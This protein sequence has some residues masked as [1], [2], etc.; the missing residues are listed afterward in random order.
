MKKWKKVMLGVLGVGCVCAIVPACV[1]SC[2]SIYGNYD[3][4]QSSTATT[5]EADY[6][7]AM[8]IYQAV[9]QAPILSSN[10]G[11]TIDSA[12]S[13]FSNDVNSLVAKNGWNQV[14]TN[15]LPVNMIVEGLDSA[16][17]GFSN[18]NFT[19]PYFDL[20]TFF[21]IKNFAVTQ[22]SN[23][24]FTIKANVTYTITDKNDKG[25][26]EFTN[27]Y[28]WDNVTVTKTL[29]KIGNCY[30]GALQLNNGKNGLELSPNSSFLNNVSVAGAFSTA[31]FNMLCNDC[32]WLPRPANIDVNASVSDQLSQIKNAYQQA[33][34]L[35][36]NNSISFSS[37]NL[38]VTNWFLS[39]DQVFCFENIYNFG[40][41]NTSYISNPIYDD[42]SNSY[43]WTYNDALNNYLASTKNTSDYSSLISTALQQAFFEY[44]NNQLIKADDS[45]LNSWHLIASNYQDNTL[46]YDLQVKI[47][48]YPKGVTKPLVA[49]F[50]MDIKESNINITPALIAID[51][52][53]TSNPAGYGG[54]SWVN[55]NNGQLSITYSDFTRSS[56]W[57]NYLDLITFNNILS[58]LQADWNSNWNKSNSI[59]NTYSFNQ[60]KENKSNDPANSI[61]LLSIVNT[62]S[63]N[64]YYYNSISNWNSDA[65]SWYYLNAINYV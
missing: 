12:T 17:L 32:Q 15:V 55:S 28:E 54:Y 47:T 53:L 59:T 9:I 25:T 4:M 48:S 21:N 36:K 45:T 6:D 44:S 7:A 62:N 41:I 57:S 10:N 39:Q 29:S 23:N 22:N 61:F 56:D 33:L 58:P 3:D 49:S 26:L 27:N 16:Y 34:A 63:N 52:D 30:Y 2:S 31:D 40:Y 14:L 65:G 11:W 43:N 19:N 1:V 60:L 35:N 24:T 50:D 13:Y 42:A 38:L 8:Q 5:K 46:T 64:L 18:E 20:T 51:K 37:N